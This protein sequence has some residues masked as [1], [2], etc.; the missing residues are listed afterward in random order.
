[1]DAF[2][3][4]KKLVL[5]AIAYGLLLLAP[6]GRSLGAGPQKRFGSIISFGDSLADTGN[7]ISFTSSQASRL[8]YGMNFPGGPT[9]R[10]SNGRL[11]VDFIAQSMGLQFLQPYPAKEDS[12]FSGSVNFAV[13]GATALNST[14]SYLSM[15]SQLE[16]FE[17]FLSSLCN[18]ISSPHPYMHLWPQSIEYILHTDNWVKD[19]RAARNERLDGHLDKRGCE[20]YIGNSLILM[21]EI[22]GNDYNGP[23]LD[24][25]SKEDVEKLVPYVI[26]AISS[27]IEKLI[28]QGAKTVVV[29]GN[30]PIGCSAAYLTKFQ[31]RNKSDYDPKTGCLSWLN[32]FA[33]QHNTQLQEELNRLCRLHADSRVKIIY[34]DYFNA[35]MKFY[36]DPAKF[37]FEK[38]T[39]ACCGGKGPYNY[40]ASV[41]CGVK[42]STVCGDPSKY[43]SWDGIHLTEAAYRLIANEIIMEYLHD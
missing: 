4:S 17:K 15:G 2:Y 36:T 28:S 27:A 38:A 8:P 6:S 23:F 39:I 1:M 26:K 41:P 9:G 13:A 43:V 25:Q 3:C 20:V 7:K 12:N 18:N 19:K 10:Y 22:G 21:G 24:G 34:A 30:L 40:D 5:I 31:S 32:N 35:A 11:I 16:W 37:G 29:P 42:G 33:Q 14:P